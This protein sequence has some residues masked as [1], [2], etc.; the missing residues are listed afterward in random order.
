MLVDFSGILKMLKENSL[1]HQ[2]ILFGTYYFLSWCLDLKMFFILM[3]RSKNILIITIILVNNL[4]SVN[5][6]WLQAFE[7]CI[8]LKGLT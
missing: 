1:F 2:K 8:T 7:N 3:S 4:I 5:C 6:L